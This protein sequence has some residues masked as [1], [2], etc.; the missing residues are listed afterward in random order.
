MSEGF[1]IAH[2]EEELMGYVEM[3]KRGEDPLFELRQRIINDY[4]SVYK[5]GTDAIVDRIRQ[6]WE[7]RYD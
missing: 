5:N 2:D 4:L 1:Y 7:T 3:L 6:D